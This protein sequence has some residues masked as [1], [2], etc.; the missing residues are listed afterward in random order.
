[1]LSLVAALQRPDD[2]GPLCLAI[3]GGQARA[4]AAGR[5]SARN[6]AKHAAEVVQFLRGDRFGGEQRGPAGAFSGISPTGLNRARWLRRCRPSARTNGVPGAATRMS[7]TPATSTP[8]PM[9]KKP[10]T[11]PI[12]GTGHSAIAAVSSREPRVCPRMP[13]KSG[14]RWTSLTSPAAAEEATSGAAQHDRPDPVVAG[15]GLQPTD[16]GVDVVQA[17]RVHRRRVDH[18]VQHAVLEQ[19]RGDHPYC[20]RQRVPVHLA[21]DIAR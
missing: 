3:V 8:N 17:E 2:R 7:H 6:Q 20:S 1:M 13:S 18:Q 9:Q 5:S 12:T 11:A 10:C 14:R 21:G 15:A 4:P 19:L 16:Q